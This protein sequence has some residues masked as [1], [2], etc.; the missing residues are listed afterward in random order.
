VSH[1]RWKKWLSNRAR[2]GLLNMSDPDPDAPFKLCLAGD[3]ET[4]CYCFTPATL[5][6]VYL[7]RRLGGPVAIYFVGR[8]YTYRCWIDGR[9]LIGLEDK[10][11]TVLVFFWVHCSPRVIN[12]FS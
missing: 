3:S 2:S 7:S 10:N 4:C 6:Y 5:I 11:F 8:E 1:H 12:V 9:L